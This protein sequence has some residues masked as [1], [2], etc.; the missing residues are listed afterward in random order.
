MNSTIWPTTATTTYY[1]VDNQNFI[2]YSEMITTTATSTY[3]NTII[4]DSGTTTHNFEGVKLDEN[5][6]GRIKTKQKVEKKVNKRFQMI[7]H[8]KIFPIM[9]EITVE[10]KYYFDGIL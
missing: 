10:H 3:G 8:K 1:K 6:V 4:P 7:E 2:N 9:E 5:G